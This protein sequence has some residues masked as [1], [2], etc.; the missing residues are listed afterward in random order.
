M[1]NEEEENEDIE[2]ELDDVNNDLQE[3]DLGSDE[4]ESQNMDDYS[5][6]DIDG[7]KEA[8]QLSRQWYK[9]IEIDSW[10]TQIHSATLGIRQKDQYRAQSRQYTASMEVRGDITFYS[11]SPEDLAKPYKERGSEKKVTDYK[12]IMAINSS[13]WDVDD[14]NSAVYKQAEKASQDYDPKKYAPLL[15]RL[16]LKT[17]S[18]LKRDKKKKGHAGRWRGTIEE[19]I[20][21]SMSSSFGENRIK[22]RPFFFLNIPGYNYRI[23]LKRTHTI[24]GERYVFTI[25]NPD[26]G[27]LSTY[28][29]KGRRFTPGKDYI[30]YDSETKEKVATIDDRK[31]NIGGKVTIKFRPEPE[32]ENL[33]RSTVFR[34]ILIHFGAV[35][36]Y[37]NEVNTKYKKI[38]KALQM[39]RKY[40]K[41]IRK[42]EKK[43]DPAA[44]EAAKIKYEEIQN[45]CKMIKSV[46]VTNSE[47]TLHYNPRRIRT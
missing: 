11:Y 10:K 26:T 45:K 23:G 27:E 40:L 46:P 31:L 12:E 28:R 2:D 4:D 38:R 16:V 25:P 6:E 20:V 5:T 8:V 14:K 29:I 17:F 32:F 37:M 19:S 18:E 34:S 33:N 22:P 44:I 1:F 43:E 15:R 3:L 39:K 21:N 30:V 41:A 42:A 35:N 9:R 47:L 13:F 7:E 24:L 36:Q